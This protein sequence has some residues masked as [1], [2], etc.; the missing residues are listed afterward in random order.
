MASSAKS[1]MTTLPVEPTTQKAVDLL[2]VSPAHVMKLLDDGAIA[3]HVAGK[4]RGVGSADLVQYQEARERAS[5]QAMAELVHQ[6]QE[7]GMG[8]D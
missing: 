1:R 5:E 8:Y 4:Q 6:S 2:N 3:S 7:L